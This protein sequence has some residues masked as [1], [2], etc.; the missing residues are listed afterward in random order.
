VKFMADNWAL[1]K[2]SK[3]EQLYF[4]WDALTY[5]VKK[6]PDTELALSIR[7][8]L[9]AKGDIPD[10][11]EA[12]GRN[13][14]ADKGLPT[15]L[16]RRARHKHNGYWLERNIRNFLGRAA[17]DLAARDDLSKSESEL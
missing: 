17:G 9:V 15:E 11:I 8:A 16:T 10:L 12:I 7:R 1:V 4:M 13:L 2:D 14:G 5:H 3:S 6:N